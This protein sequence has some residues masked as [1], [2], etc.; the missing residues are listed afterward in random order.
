MLLCVV[1][2]LVVGAGLLAAE[3]GPGAPSPAAI[4]RTRKTVKMLDDVY[5]SAIVLIT[6]KYVNDTDDFPAGGAA[7]EWFKQISEKGWHEI[8]LLDASGQPTVAG[9][10]A[11]DEFERTAIAS[12][13]S[14]KDYVEKIET[15]DGKYYLRALTPVPVALKKCIMCHPH[16]AKVK[17][18][19]AIG[20]LSYQLAI[21]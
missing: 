17:P 1:T 11:K 10:V 13:K 8:R 3:K 9:N 7:V 18:G 5:K 2:G 6:D 20:A 12:L 4:A 19:E 16:Y 15:H 14:G 21:E